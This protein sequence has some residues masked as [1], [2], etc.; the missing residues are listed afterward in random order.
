MDVQIVGGL[1]KYTPRRIHKISQVLK[2]PE[3]TLRHRINRM[4]RLGLMKMSINPKYNYLGMLN[5]LV[6]IQYDPKH[7]DRLLESMRQ[8]PF[9]L[10]VQKIYSV[11]GLRN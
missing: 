5:G 4:L 7:T 6:R 1:N 9:A 11:K 3:S 8:N 2:I 10:C